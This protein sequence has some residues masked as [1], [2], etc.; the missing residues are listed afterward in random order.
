MASRP[1]PTTRT[2]SYL[3]ARFDVLVFDFAITRRTFRSPSEYTYEQ[4]DRDLERVVRDTLSRLGARRPP[5]SSIH[6]RRTAMKHA[7]E[8][9]SA[10][11]ALAVRS[12]E[13]AADRPPTVSR[14]EGLRGTAHRMGQGP[15]AA[16]RLDRGVDAGISAISRDPIVGRGRARSDGAF[17]PARERRRRRLRALCAPEQEFTIY[18]RRWS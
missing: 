8:I 2:G 11:D 15:A 18:R 16:V 7:V 6:V 5:A 3:A 4:F 13:C 12:A 17:G 1:M 9:G 10:W 14:D